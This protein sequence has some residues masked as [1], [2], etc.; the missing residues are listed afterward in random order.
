MLAALT[1]IAAAILAMVL[2]RRSSLRNGP[3]SRRMNRRRSNPAWCWPMSCPGTSA[4]LAHSCWK[5]SSLLARN[6]WMLVGHCRVNWRSATDGFCAHPSPATRI[7][8]SA[9][10]HR[11]LRRPAA[12]PCLSRSD[13][14]PLPLAV[15]GRHAV[16][17]L[18]HRTIYLSETRSAFPSLVTGTTTG[19]RGMVGNKYAD[20]SVTRLDA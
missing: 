5:T 9:I 6:R 20:R 10:C 2:V 12:R 19:R 7:K 3:S 16:G 14:E 13:A 4:A 11:Q 15:I 1:C 17:L 18:E 8:T